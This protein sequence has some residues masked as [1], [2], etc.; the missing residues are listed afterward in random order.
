MK[1]LEH[2]EKSAKEFLS[3]PQAL[4]RSFLHNTVPDFPS[5]SSL[6]ITGM[7]AD[8][9]SP[10]IT[11]SLLQGIDEPTVQTEESSDSSIN[12]SLPDSFDQLLTVSPKKPK[13][14]SDFNPD[15]R[16]EINKGLE[17]LGS[18][19]CVGCRELSRDREVLQLRLQSLEGDLTRLKREV[20]VCVCMCMYMCMC[21]CRRVA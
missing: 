10:D 16:S 17:R 18:V 14:R 7:M 2:L 8:R 21:M 11:G 1:K 6:D 13:I 5:L 12:L 15:V 9:L 3:S 19:Q 4:I 20:C